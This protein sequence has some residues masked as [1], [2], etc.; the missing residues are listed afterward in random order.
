MNPGLRQA[1]YAVVLG[2]ACYF[3]SCKS[4][5]QAPTP[6]SA[7]PGAG[8]AD[9]LAA[10]DAPA[11]DGDAATDPDAVNS[12][13]PDRQQVLADLV[14]IVMLPGYAELHA[15]AT[16][17]AAALAALRQ[18]PAP[19]PCWRPA[20][21]GARRAPRGGAPPPSAWARPTISG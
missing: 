4:Q 17:L 13:R 11:G 10:G 6:D 1:V 18:T 2:A 15:Q 19:R 9:A 3:L 5:D 8:D 14:R 12:G 21:A 20:K 16:K 7:A